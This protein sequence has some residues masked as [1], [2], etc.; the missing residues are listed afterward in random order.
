[1][2]EK[3]YAL[4]LRLFPSHFRE[5]YESVGAATEPGS[6]QPQRGA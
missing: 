1:M 6:N 3:I 4:L 2:F 5:A